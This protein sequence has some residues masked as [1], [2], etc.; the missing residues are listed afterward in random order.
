MLSVANIDVSY[1][2]A[3]VLHNIEM[4][5][6]KGEMVFITG[7]N[8]AGKTT[9][10]K[11]I[12][13]FMKPDS[14]TIEFEGKN[15]IGIPPERVALLGVRYVFQDKRVFSNLTVRE[16]LEV[17]AYPV[18]EKITDAIEK[19]ISIYPKIEKFLNMRAGSLS[20]GQRQILLIGRALIGKPK[21]LLIDE[22]TEGLAAGTIND[23]LNV[24]SKMKGTFSLLIVE[25]NLSVVGMLADRV[26]MMK[27]GKIIKEMADKKEINNKENLEKYL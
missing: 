2:H 14:G 6:S 19:V 13:G 3:K 27:E 25:Q 10:L 7:R 16:N 26:Y 24:L 21:L 20:G 9:L 23:I 22:P 17:A 12:A 1:G 15:I 8:G 18:K 4:Q 11:T 5:I